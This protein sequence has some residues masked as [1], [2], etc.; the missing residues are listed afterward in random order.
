MKELVMSHLRLDPE[1]RSMETHTDL[2]FCATRMPLKEESNWA[3]VTGC[4]NSERESRGRGTDI[5]GCFCQ[6]LAW[7][8]CMRSGHVYICLGFKQP[9]VSEQHSGLRQGRGRHP[10]CKHQPYA[11]ERVEI[12][13]P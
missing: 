3:S 13:W 6:L 12:Q 5:P 1:T 11:D 8:Q 7:G 4:K 9:Q 2:R 10:D